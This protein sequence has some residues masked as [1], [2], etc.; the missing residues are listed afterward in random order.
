MAISWKVAK[1]K[2]AAAKAAPVEDPFHHKSVIDLLAEVNDDPFAGPVLAEPSGH[3][4]GV[5]HTPP[6]HGQV[7]ELVDFHD[8]GDYEAEDQINVTDENGVETSIPNPAAGRKRVETLAEANVVTSLIKGTD[9]PGDKYSGLHNPVIDI[10]VPVHLVPS[11]TPGHGHLY[12]EKP[13][14]WSDLK[15]L[16]EV[17]VEVGLVEPGYLGASDKR[18]HTCVRLPGMKK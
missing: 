9:V 1:G 12:V 3:I 7:L 5:D 10:D 15:K 8:K 18:G 13:M 6:L 14:P 17:M 4:P 16:L 11:S 2:M